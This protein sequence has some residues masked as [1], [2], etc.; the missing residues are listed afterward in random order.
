MNTIF[1][2]KFQLADVISVLNGVFVFIS[3]LLAGSDNWRKRQWAW[4]LGLSVQLLLVLFGWLTVHYGFFLN[5]LPATAFAW[6]LYRSIFPARINLG[7]QWSEEARTEMQD[8]LRDESFTE[9]RTSYPSYGGPAH[10]GVNYNIQAK[11]LP[12]EP[13]YGPPSGSGVSG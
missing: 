2:I 13:E 6:N 12:D 4:I 9:T 10:R 5:L 8:A 7:K 1:I 3:V 11:Q